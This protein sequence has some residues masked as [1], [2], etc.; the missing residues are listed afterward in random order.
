MQNL[1]VNRVEKILWIS[2]VMPIL[3]SMSLL[4]AEVTRIMP[5]GDSITP[6]YWVNSS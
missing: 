2:I 4:G 6:W 5:L 1:R 3:L